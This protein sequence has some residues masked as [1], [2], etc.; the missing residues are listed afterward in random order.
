MSDPVYDLASRFLRSGGRI[1]WEEWH[2]LDVEAQAAFALAGDHV[3]RD[4]AYRAADAV[5]ALFG[6]DDE[7]Q[8]ASAVQ[9]AA[10]DAVASLRRAS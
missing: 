4:D 5:G 6:L 10:D 3:R 1:S 7:T 2:E 8:T 9:R